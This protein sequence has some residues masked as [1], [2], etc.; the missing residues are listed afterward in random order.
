MGGR[1]RLCISGGAPLNPD[2][3]EFFFAIGIPILEGYGLTETSPVITLNRPGRERPG[4]VGQLIPGVEVR[5]AENGEILTRGPHVMLGYFEN[6]EATQESI[7]DG[8]FRTGDIGQIDSEGY[9]FITDRLKQLLINAGGKKVAP[10][11][12]EA[13]LKG[14]RWVAEVVLIGDRMPYFVALIVPDFA[15]L[16]LAA[17]SHGWG[18]TNRAELV[19]R[20]EAVAL[21]Q[22]AVDRT[23]DGRARF[24]QIKR[25]ALLE[26]DLLEERDELTPTQKV[27]RKVIQNNYADKIAQ[28]YEGHTLPN[29]SSPAAAAG[30]S[31]S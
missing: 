4:S 29:L 21:I 30:N 2:V 17:Q 10:Q 22:E 3:L 1:L 27:R 13:D 28:L 20:P 31:D 25:F 9:L 11:P 8:W 18:Y 23:N 5:I 14:S 26:E 7:Q 6:E 12:I 24:E 16:E 15:Q 19:A